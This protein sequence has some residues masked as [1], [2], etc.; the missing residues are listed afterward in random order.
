[1]VLLGGMATMMLVMGIGRF[2]YTPIL[3]DMI[4]AGLLDVKAAGWLASSNFV[5]YFLGA[6]LATPFGRPMRRRLLIAFILVSILTTAGMGLTRDL[7]L[8]HGLRFLSGIAS[9]FGQVYI[10][11][12]VMEALSRRGK[13]LWIGWLI[14]GVGLGV[15]ISSLVVE[16]AQKN[17]VAW[18]WQWLASGGLAALLAV[19]AL[20][21]AWSLRHGGAAPLPAGTVAPPRERLFTFHFTLLFIAYAGLG[22]GYVVQATYL[23]TMVRSLPQLATFS[24]LAWMVFGLA[25]APSNIFWQ[26]IAARL[27]VPAALI[28]AFLL[29]ASGLLVPVLWHSVPGV[30]IGAAALGSTLVGITALCLQQA[31]DMAGDQFPRA[32]ALMTAGFGLG[33]IA[34]PA[35]AAQLVGPGN[36]FLPPTIMTSAVL[37]L[38]ALLCIPLL[39]QRRAR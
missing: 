6:L 5:G 37:T 23:P 36:D 16:L 29:Q 12:F 15:V 22:I 11:G 26:F 9:A 25:A 10:S 20:A 17:G 14:G 27:G 30:I 3:P 19:P 1:M 4:G 38:S 31:R 28:V 2:V 33:Q 8:W 21:T 7:L 32:I 34:G 13:P 18:D 39:R 24:T 35:I